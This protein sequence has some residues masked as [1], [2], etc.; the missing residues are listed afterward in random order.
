MMRIEQLKDVYYN[1]A[2][3]LADK[4]DLTEV[5]RKVLK[6]AETLF[7]SG[8]STHVTCLATACGNAAEA[9]YEALQCDENEDPQNEVIDEFYYLESIIDRREF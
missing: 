5:H 3:D 2:L 6:L 7:M 8:L 1:Y 4:G 9:I